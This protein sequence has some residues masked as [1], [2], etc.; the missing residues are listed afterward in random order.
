MADSDI[1]AEA[2]EQVQ[3]WFRC[4]CDPAW[5]DRRMH[6]PDCLL[7]LGDDVLTLLTVTLRRVRA[8]ARAD[9]RARVLAEIGAAA[10]SSSAP[11]RCTV[12]ADSDIPAEAVEAAALVRL[13]Q[14]DGEYDASHLTVADF[15]EDVT[16]MLAAAL[17]HLRARCQCPQPPT[18]APGCPV[19]AADYWKRRCEA[20]WDRGDED[21]R[22]RVLAEVDA[23]LDD[24]QAMTKWAKRRGV[25]HWR[26]YPD[27]YLRDVLGAGGEQLMGDDWN[28]ILIEQRDGER[29]RVVA[30]VDRIAENIMPNPTYW[31]LMTQLRDVLGTEGGDDEA[32]EG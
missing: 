8:E 19:H 9:E 27:G 13:R 21:T 30:E 14:Y 4:R 6:A 10:T 24:N 15:A 31:E 26:A 16:E 3:L 29:A 25:N 23:A 22:V 7:E 12:M 1:P 28:A 20:A 11:N 17:P 32:K 2:V 5:T 18:T